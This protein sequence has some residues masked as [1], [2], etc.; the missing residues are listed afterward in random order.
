MRFSYPKSLIGDPGGVSFSASSLTKASLFHLVI[1]G[2][3]PYR[4]FTS[5]FFSR[6]VIHRAPLL[7]AY[8]PGL[9]RSPSLRV[10]DSLPSLIPPAA[11]IRTVVADA[12]ARALTY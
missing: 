6:L 12:H 5:F 8:P 11:G 1:R 10:K 9:L 4:P 7:R 2:D 3:E